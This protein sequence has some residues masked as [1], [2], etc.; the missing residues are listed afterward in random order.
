VSL[1]DFVE[2]RDVKE[3]LRLDV[4]KPW[5]RVHAQIKALPLTTNY[6]CTGT[7]F[8]YLMRF[9][10]EKLN[11]CAKRTSWVAEQSL[12]L[13]QAHCRSRSTLKRASRIV[14][15]AREHYCSYLKNKREEKPGRKLIL[16]AVDLAQL[17]L[18]YRIGVFDLRPVERAVVTDLGNLLA[19]LR[20]DDFRAKRTCLLNPIFG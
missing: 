16:A 12:A 10:V 19:L 6:H 11:S 18:V 3:R 9:Y 15:T 8:D 14:E 5:F 2:L 17:D 4:E 7:A 1:T 20:T 13:L